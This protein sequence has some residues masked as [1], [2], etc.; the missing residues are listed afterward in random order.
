MG[1]YSI[2]P[3][4]QSGI[5]GRARSYE[6]TGY[7]GSDHQATLAA[8]NNLPINE[9]MAVAR[10]FKPWARAQIEAEFRVSDDTWRRRLQAAMLKL[11]TDL[12]LSV[13]EKQICG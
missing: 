6:P 3:M 10:Q 13:A 11:E 2:C 5:P 8:I 9:R 7:S 4:L 1:W 12:R